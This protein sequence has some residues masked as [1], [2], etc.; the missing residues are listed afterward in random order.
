MVQVMFGVVSLDD[1][2]DRFS[3]DARRL[4]DRWLFCHLIAILS[5]EKPSRYQHGSILWNFRVVVSI[6]CKKGND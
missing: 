3:S 5:S 6:N 1:F 2:L 4:L